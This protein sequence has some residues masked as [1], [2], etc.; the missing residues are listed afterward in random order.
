MAR[1][2]EFKNAIPCPSR[3]PI[4]A[5]KSGTF[6]FAKKRNFLLCVDTALHSKLGEFSLQYHD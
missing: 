2:K 3:T 6:Y 5:Q 1:G 4:P